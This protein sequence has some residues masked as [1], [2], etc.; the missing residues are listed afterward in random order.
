VAVKKSARFGGLAIWVGSSHCSCPS[1]SRADLVW[2]S[3]APNFIYIH[4]YIYIY[5]YIF[6]HD[7]AKIYGPP[8]FLQN[9]TY[10]V[11]AHGLRDITV[12]PTA[13]GAASSGPLVWDRHSASYPTAL[14]A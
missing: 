13:V 1:L 4:I 6:Y 12:W 3:A 9:Y 10:V 5:I 7:F 2:P 11:V 14:G 8:E